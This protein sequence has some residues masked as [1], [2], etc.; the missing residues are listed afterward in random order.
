M[1]HG[2]LNEARMAKTWDELTHH[3]KQRYFDALK[4]LAQEMET[5][6]FSSP[7]EAQVQRESSE[8]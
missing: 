7:I 3:Q 8:S 6:D 5:D 4:Q 2:R 1:P